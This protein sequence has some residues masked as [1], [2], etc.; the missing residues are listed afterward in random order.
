MLIGNLPVKKTLEHKYQLF[1]AIAFM[2]TLLDQITKWLVSSRIPLY[3]SMVVIKGFLNLVHIRNTGVA[4]G[5]LSGFHV[6]YR[7]VL[8]ALISL[9]A[10]FFI[11]MYLR[12]LQMGQ[13]A[14][15]VG[16]SVVFGGAFGNFIDRIMYGE[17][18]DFIDCYVGRF[19]WPAF[20]VADS[21]ITVGIAFLLFT[22][23]RRS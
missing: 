5:M 16:I 20:N 13:K 3:G 12:R 1:F 21:A 23:I 22:I 7:A 4:F 2:V 11:I 10:M 14:W 6:P 17:V 18:I 19:H 8:L 9:A 15:L